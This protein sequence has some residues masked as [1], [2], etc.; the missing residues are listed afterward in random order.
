M[1]RHLLTDDDK[2]RLYERYTAGEVDEKV[3][4]LLLG[5]E[6]DTMQEDA[7]D[8]DEAIELDTSGMFQE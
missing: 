3:V 4:H 1:F 7:A 5:D 6:L 2:I 8:F